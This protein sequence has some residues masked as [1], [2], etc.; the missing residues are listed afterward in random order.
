AGAFGPAPGSTGFG[1]HTGYHT[2]S[3][4]FPADG[5]YTLSVGAVN[6]GD[7]AVS[8]AVLLDNVQLSSL[9]CEPAGAHWVLSPADGPGNYELYATWVPSPGNATN[10]AYQV[11]DS[12]GTY[13]GTVVVNQQLQPNDVLVNGSLWKDLGAF[14][15]TTGTFQVFF[16][17][18]S[19]SGNV[20]ADALFVSPLPAG[21]PVPRRGNGPASVPASAPPA[22]PPPAP[23]RPPAPG[24]P[25]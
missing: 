3:S 13:L 5:T 4:T 24:P 2:F 23:P 19:V 1:S 9:G 17:T 18:S 12:D 25:P 20:V 8:S 22:P 6:V 11:Y 21:P 15:T 14:A 7:T 10:V 16:D